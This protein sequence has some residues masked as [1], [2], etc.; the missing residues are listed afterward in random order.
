MSCLRGSVVALLLVAGSA[1]CVWGQVMDIA[2]GTSVTVN[3]PVPD[4][5]CLTNNGTLLIDTGGSLSITGNVLSVIG[6]HG[7]TGVMIERRRGK[8]WA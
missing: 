2:P 1:S 7:E 6:A 5:L 3:T 8:S 4:V